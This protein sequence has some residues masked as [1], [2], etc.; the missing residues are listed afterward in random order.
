MPSSSPSCLWPRPPLPPGRA[1]DSG[2]LRQAGRAH[3]RTGHQ[4]PRCCS[5]PGQ[6][7][8]SSMGPEDVPKCWCCGPKLSRWA[9]GGSP[10]QGHCGPHP[11]C[12][13]VLGQD[14]GSTLS[15]GSQ[16]HLDGQV[17]GQLHPLVE[18]EEAAGA[19]PPARPAFPEMGSEELRLA[20]FQDWPLTAVV[21]PE[22]LAAAGFFHTG[23]SWG[24]GGSFRALLD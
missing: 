18:E 9:A 7:G 3:S 6:G 21:R 20:S 14:V 4:G 22:L 2:A 16:D 23:E 8:V 1:P 15:W 19:T 11:L 17:L 12:G 5:R 24:A 13:Q 10:V